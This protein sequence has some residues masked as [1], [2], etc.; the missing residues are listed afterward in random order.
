[1]RLLWSST[2]YCF[3][4]IV[5][6][7]LFLSFERE[8]FM[9]EQ[10]KEHLEKMNLFYKSHSTKLPSRASHTVIV[11][12]QKKYKQTTIRDLSFCLFFRIHVKYFG[13]HIKRCV[14]M[15]SELFC[16]FSTKSTNFVGKITWNYFET[17]FG[18]WIFI[19]TIFKL[20]YKWIDMVSYEIELASLHHIKSTYQ[21][22]AIGKDGLT[23]HV[24]IWSTNN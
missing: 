8:T 18:H 22:E 1:M 2:F 5:F 14:C 7:P 23:A 16:I 3:R 19:L 9:L 21:L 11:M 20:V 6:S 13:K 4:W 15:L 17:Q 10:W 12:W 24:K